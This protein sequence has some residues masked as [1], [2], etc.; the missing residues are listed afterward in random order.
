MF[1]RRLE[2]VAD[3]SEVQEE[4]PEV[5]SGAL[6]IEAAF[7][8]GSGPTV[9]GLGGYGQDQLDV[10]S[11]LARVERP[12][13]PA[14]LNGAPVPDVVQVHPVVAGRVEVLRPAVVVAVP[15]AVEL[16]LGFGTATLNLPD[17]FIT[18]RLA[19]VV[20]PVLVDTQGG[21]DE[22]F[23][24]VDDLGEVGEGPTVERRGVHVNVD[25]AAPVHLGPAAA[26]RPDHFLKDWYVLVGEDRADHLGPQVAG[27]IDERA[28]GDHLPG[29]TLVVDDLPGV[30]THRSPYVADLTA[31]HRLDGPGHAL[32]CS[33]D[34]LD[35]DS[36]VDFS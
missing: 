32:P 21:E 2:L 31:H 29:T 9:Q 17:E 35:L 10:G 11:D 22:R 26:H 8:A 25:S 7:A 28:V 19:V 34:G 5:V 12:F 15:D 30:E 14:E 27:D 20:L 36:E 23:L 18:H 4:N 13:E 1:A 6:R 3:E 16:V 33:F 24:L